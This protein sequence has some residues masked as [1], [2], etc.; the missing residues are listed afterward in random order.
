MSRAPT[1]TPNPHS[2]GQKANTPDRHRNDGAHWKEHDQPEAPRTGRP[3]PEKDYPDARE[4][5]P[6]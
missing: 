4:K 2:D 1:H 6:R 5:A 3:D